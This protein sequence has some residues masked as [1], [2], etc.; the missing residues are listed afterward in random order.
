MG[1]NTRV[2]EFVLGAI[3]M[4]ELQ[5][6]LRRNVS[7]VVGHEDEILKWL[8]YGDNIVKVCDVVLGHAKIIKEKI[9][10]IIATFRDEIDYSRTITDLIKVGKY[11]EV[12]EGVNE[13]NYPSD[14]GVIKWRVEYAVFDFGRDILSDE[15]IPEIKKKGYL[16]TTIKE[17]LIFRERHTNVQQEYS[18]IM[19]LGSFSESGDVVYLRRKGLK[20]LIKARPMDTLWSSSCRFLGIRKISSY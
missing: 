4:Q 1:T 14:E 6:A 18:I 17:T 9:D 13:E 16:P 5:E 20:C 15:V 8:A 3:P 12:S 7:L 11:D 19:A 10:Y 2:N